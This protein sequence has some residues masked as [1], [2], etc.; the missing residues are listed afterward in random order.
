MATKK[1]S[2]IGYVLAGRYKI[3]EQIGKGGMS[4]VY[5][6]MDD[7]LHK[8]WAVKEFKQT[9]ARAKDAQFRKNLIAEAELMKNLDNPAL[10][11]IVDIIDADKTV[12][13]VM[14][15]IEGRD[16]GAL[17]KNSKRLLLEEE[18]IDLGLQL[19]SVLDY[20][21]T[22]DPR[23]GK[24]VIVYR[25]LKPENIIVDDRGMARLID[26]GIARKFDEEKSSDTVVMGT[27]GFMAPEQLSATLQSD[28][29]AD[30]YSLGITL[31]YLVTGQNPDENTSVHPIREYNPKLSEGLEAIIAKCVQA[32]RENRYQSCREIAYDLEHYTELT[33]EYRAVQQKKVNIFKGL[34]IAAISC[35]VAG[36]ICFIISTLLKGSTYDAQIAEAVSITL[37]A[38]TTPEDSDYKQKE[39]AYLSAID[40]DDGRV[41]AYRGLLDDV[42]MADD[43]LSSVESE[44]FYD[45]L[46]NHASHCGASDYASLC[47]DYADKLFFYKNDYGQAKKWY[48]EA[49]ATNAL[50]SAYATTAQTYISICDFS[51]NLS[52]KEG[53]D[54][55]SENR[56]YAEY[57]NN[58]CERFDAVDNEES[59]TFSKLKLYE[60]M[61]DALTGPAFVQEFKNAEIS[62]Y[63]LIDRVGQIRAKAEALGN[64]KLNYTQENLRLDTI[65]RCETAKSVIDRI[66][67][68]VIDTAHVSSA[69]PADQGSDM[70]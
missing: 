32:D 9:G 23:K 49:V 62:Q 37:N 67:A 45:L 42:Y 50:E 57:W 17:V 1:N 29:R 39:A 22:P 44:R 68:S 60:L 40:T 25:D 2:R 69:V 47:F 19:C 43:S 28:P 58:L 53:S 10:P 26:F 48:E 27:K 41:E 55:V 15:Y 18:V 4:V 46:N 36:I 52:R 8:Q 35:L 59:T 31:H 34:A 6:A 63:D 14:D 56:N 11:R 61:L 66:Y 12:F 21:H 24:P 13:I 51:E 65:S 5:L 70:Q 54:S 30:I 64:E 20:L 38:N 3:L 33:Q 7:T 16:L